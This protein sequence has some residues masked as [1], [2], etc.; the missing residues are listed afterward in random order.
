MFCGFGLLGVT[1]AKLP[2][3]RSGVENKLDWCDNLVRREEWRCLMRQLL[4]SMVKEGR[5][6]TEASSCRVK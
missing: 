6:G 4:R 3:E 1:L 2:L 5:R